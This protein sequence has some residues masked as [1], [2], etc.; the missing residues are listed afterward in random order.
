MNMIA[1]LTSIRISAL[2]RAA[3]C[4]TVFA[5][6]CHQALASSVARLIDDVKNGAIATTTRAGWA[7]LVL[8]S[9]PRVD[10]EGLTTIIED[11]RDL[12]LRIMFPSARVADGRQ[13][14]FAL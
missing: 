4:E 10:N 13:Q 1:S 11:L 8:E 6:R 5:M 9:S 7:T 14:A 12:G 3:A 2:E